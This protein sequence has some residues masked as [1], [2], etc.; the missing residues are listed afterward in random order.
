MATIL[1]KLGRQDEAR[2]EMAIF[3]RLQSASTSR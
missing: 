1:R 3:T 2:R